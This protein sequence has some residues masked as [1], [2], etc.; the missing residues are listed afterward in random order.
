MKT[1]PSNPAQS[2][3]DF[4]STPLGVWGRRHVFSC[5]W[6]SAIDSL[7]DAAT[8]RVKSALIPAS[9]FPSRFHPTTLVKFEQAA[10][11]MLEPATMYLILVLNH[12]R[13]Q[14]QFLK[15]QQ[16]NKSNCRG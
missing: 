5:E 1:I 11:H 9:I 13:P 7:I 6:S 10:A 2:H 15:C 3:D 16:R 8:R 14:K 12:H 4:D